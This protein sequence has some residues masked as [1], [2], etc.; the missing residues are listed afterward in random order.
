M[1]RAKRRLIKWNRYTDRY[2]KPPFGMMGVVENVG[3][4]KAQWKVYDKRLPTA[5]DIRTFRRSRRSR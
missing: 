5:Q 2:I 4:V 3:L 1:N